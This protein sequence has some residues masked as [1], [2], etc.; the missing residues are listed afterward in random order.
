MPV[1]QELA[2]KYSEVC[3]SWDLLAS[4][5]DKEIQFLSI[6]RTLDF[7]STVA[8]PK[9]WNYER[10]LF[11]TFHS[12]SCYVLR[13]DTGTRQCLGH[14]PFSLFSWDFFFKHIEGQ[15]SHHHHGNLGSPI[16]K[17]THRFPVKFESLATPCIW[18]VE[19]LPDCKK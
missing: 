2:D 7:V 14:V 10:F 19:K 1:D 6:Q 17:L 9:N 8:I 11:N 5:L 4:V 16:E 13:E 12:I 3:F 15:E 18:G